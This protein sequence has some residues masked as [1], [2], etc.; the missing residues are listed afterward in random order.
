MTHIQYYELCKLLDKKP[1]DKELKEMGFSAVDGKYDEEL[2][3]DIGLLK[4]ER[5]K[6]K[7][8][9]ENNG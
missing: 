1:S 5:L 7:C 6:D 8:R 4:F 9:R 3:Y 2:D